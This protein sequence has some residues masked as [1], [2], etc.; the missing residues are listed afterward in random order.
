MLKHVRSFWNQ[1][2][3]LTKIYTIGARRIYVSIDNARLQHTWEDSRDIF[4]IKDIATPDLYGET[5]IKFHARRGVEC[6]DLA[7]GLFSSGRSENSLIGLNLAF[8]LPI[9]AQIP[10]IG[11][12]N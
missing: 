9:A 8:I 10:Q 1:S 12:Q 6:A 4:I 2:E 7:E 3:I 11:L 5:I